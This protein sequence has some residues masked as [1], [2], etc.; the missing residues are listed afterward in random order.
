L[1]HPG[2]DPGSRKKQMK[3]KLN[4]FLFIFI[5]LILFCVVFF[6]A[7]QQ[8]NP[9]PYLTI[10]NTKVNLIIA[11]TPAKQVQGLSYQKDL[12]RDE[13]MLF[14]FSQ[15][16]NLTFWMKDMNF[17]LDII[18]INDNK[19]IKIDKNLSP[20]GESPTRAYNS[21]IPVN[22]VLE[23]N[24]GYSDAHNIKVGDEVKYFLK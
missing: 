3:K 18:W 8:K 16:Q 21:K 22:Y 2:L 6:I 24:A 13:G 14:I 9:R 1:C 5:I 12:G 19:I 10:N 20:E 7:K 23:V 11:D 17:P 15:K 4:I